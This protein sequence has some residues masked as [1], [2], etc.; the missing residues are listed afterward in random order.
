[1]QK[2]SERERILDVEDFLSFFSFIV[3]TWYAK[4]TIE[5]LLTNSIFSSLSGKISNK[6]QND[7]EKQSF[8]RA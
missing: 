1:M 2:K 3:Y 6:E 4:F 5:R 7:E 8:S